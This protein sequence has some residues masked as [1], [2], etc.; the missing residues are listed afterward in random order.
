[1]SKSI[2]R[3]QFLFDVFVTAMEGGIG[4]WSIA[5]EYHWQNENKEDLEGFYALISDCEAEDDE[6][7]EFPKDS[8]IDQDVIVKGI[9]KIIKGEVKISDV[10]RQRIIEAS[11]N[12]DA[13]EIDANDADCIVQVGLLGELIFG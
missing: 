9:N 5:S 4:Y 8:R 10:I 6:D 12:N 7:G 3:Q 2:E 1:M 13:G 11:R